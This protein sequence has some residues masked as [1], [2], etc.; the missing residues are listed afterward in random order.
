MYSCISI[1]NMINQ[2]V[3]SVEEIRNI[4]QTEKEENSYS[5]ENEKMRRMK[6]NSV[7]LVE[8]LPWSLLETF[9]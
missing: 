9:D 7:T 5:Y 3:V 1:E 4:K 6:T 8:T 2:N